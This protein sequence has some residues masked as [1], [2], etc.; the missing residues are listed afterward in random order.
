MLG[1]VAE[2]AFGVLPSVVQWNTAP[3]VE[4]LTVSVCALLKLPPFGVI[5]GAAAC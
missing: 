2:D 5:T 4:S 1:Q 3:G